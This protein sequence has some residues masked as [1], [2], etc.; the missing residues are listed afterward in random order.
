M[1]SIIIFL[2]S[3]LVTPAALSVP[4][5]Y[6]RA[7]TERTT[8]TM[9]A[10]YDLE[11]VDGMAGDFDCHG[12]DL[13]AFVPLADM[14]CTSSG[15]DVWGWTDP[16]DGR[17]YALMGCNNG[18]SFVDIT[19]PVNPVYL[20][21]LPTH[22]VSSD[23]RDTKVFQNHA[24][25]VSEAGGHGLQVFDLTQLR[26]VTDPPVV[27][28]A[29]AHND[30][31]GSAHNI[32]VNEATGYA[33]VVGSTECDGGLH[34]IDV[35]D[36][37][38]PQVAG[39][40]SEDG[41]THDVQCVIYHGPDETYQGREIC[42]ASNGDFSLPKENTLTIVDV[43]DKSDLQML[44]RE[45]YDGAGYTHQG[46]LTEDHAQFLL[47]DET[48][49]I[50]FGHNTRTRVWDVGNL[51]KPVII[52]IFDSTE[53][54]T[55]HNLYIKGNFCYQSNYSA[56]LRILDLEDV[57]EGTLVE[58]AYFDVIPHGY[59]PRH[60]GAGFFGTWSNYPFFDSGIVVASTMGMEGEPGGLFVTR[61]RLEESAIEGTVTDA[62]T[63]S[64]LA[65]VHIE[66]TA[67][68][69]HDGTTGM[70]GSY[71]IGI[72]PGTYTV[73]ASKPGYHS[74]SVSGVAVAEDQP[75][76]ADLALQPAP[77][78]DI[79]PDTIELEAF[80]GDGDSELLT[81]T[82]AGGGDLSWN[83]ETE[84]VAGIF[85]ASAHDPS[86]DEV[87]D[88][89]EFSVD[90]AANGGE[91]AVFSLPAGVASRGDVVGV[92]FG[93]TVA[94]ISGTSTWASDLCMQVE[95]PGGVT[96]VVGGFSGDAAGCNVNDWDFDGASN[97][98]AYESVHLDAFDPVAG[99]EGE[100]TVTFMND[101]NDTGAATMTWSEVAVTLHKTI[102]QHPADV[103]WLDVTPNAGTT[104]GGESVEV[105][106]SGDASALEPG[107][108]EARL[109]ITTND[110]HATLVPVM[111]NLEVSEMPPGEF[112]VDPAQLDFGQVPTGTVSQTLTAELINTGPMTVT[113]TSID[114]PDAPF[115]RLAGDDCGEPAF[116]L[117]PEASCELAFT[118]SPD[119]QESHAAEITVMSETA[120]MVT[121]AL[122]GEGVVPVV[123][124]DV[125]ALYLGPVAPGEIADSDEVTLT[126]VG[127]ANLELDALAIGGSHPE[128][129]S[130]YQDGCSNEVLE[131]G[132]DCSFRIRFSP[133]QDSI[134]QADLTV[135]SNAADGESTIELIG[136][137]IRIFDDRFEP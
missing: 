28:E 6:D 14:G 90:S 83:I 37:L 39:C 72:L 58:A 65:D 75:A 126:N 34:I 70:N 66:I 48:D 57:A 46:W 54:A 50:N 52:G 60:D 84:P 69:P 121:L 71:Q 35:N 15:N 41:Y 59:Q 47:N 133:D 17:E 40:F 42:F 10:L 117:A 18:V 100:W 119:G 96:F 32:E 132:Q 99:D 38:D 13:A 95:S 131:P 135:T 113:I 16:D 67:G 129:F 116:D 111:V 51:D 94:G 9:E 24:F 11:C 3:L 112:T 23:W 43:T 26:T 109:C 80:A 29:S 8:S 25:V 62:V 93:G 107:S 74:T 86:L 56:G 45:T 137:T 103:D 2:A 125:N 22:T 73:T 118:Y 124:L 98:G 36:P 92:S 44:G 5:S 127:E 87:L 53:N 122:A 20:G 134:Y 64:V 30:S 78:A 123:S 31:F 120:G 49:E 77:L 1:R 91:P 130:L 21:R 79:S 101:W 136:R 81:I 85:S 12:V 110:E 76:I 19:D 115:S 82:N 105:T 7:L 4:L 27:F 61:P 128:V 108:Y 33:Y 104:A 88:I 63:G 102:C 89:G 97:D 68:L 114:A 106:V 55:D